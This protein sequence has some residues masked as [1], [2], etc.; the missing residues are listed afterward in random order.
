MLSGTRPRAVF[1]DR[2]ATLHVYVPTALVDHVMVTSGYSATPQVVELIDPK[3]MHDPAIERIAHE[4]LAEMRDEQPL[5]RLRVDALGQDLVIQLL[6]RHSNLRGSRP[7][8]PEQARGGLAPRRLNQV[9]DFLEAHLTEDVSLAQ[10]ASVA[11][12]SETHFC[13]AFK[14]AT[15]LPAHQYLL[16]RRIERARGMLRDRDVSLVEVALRLGFSSQSHFT[17]HFRRLTGTTPARYRDEI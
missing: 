10:L 7:L 17:S 1:Y 5:S 14:Q 3:C 16:H 15:G 8:A 13:R 11:G 4:M 9:T 2:Q 6:R 12:L